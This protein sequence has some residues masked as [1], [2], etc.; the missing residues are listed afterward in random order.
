M[1]DISDALTWVKTKENIWTADGY[2]IRL[3][4]DVYTLY[5]E[6]GVRVMDR[7]KLDDCKK[8]A[9][10]IETQANIQVEEYR[11]KDEIL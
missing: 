8:L 9:D 3:T 4:G 6:G 1:I 7:F 5:L 11:R 2:I 10:I